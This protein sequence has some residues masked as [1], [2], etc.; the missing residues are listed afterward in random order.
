[1][2]FRD[3]GKPSLADLLGVFLAVA[4]VWIGGRRLFGDSDPAMHVAT[5]DWILAHGRI[6][7]TDPFSLTWAGKEWFAHEWLADVLWALVHRIAGWA[8]LVALAA[9]LVALTYVVLY[10]FLVRAG[11]H[12]LP[13]FVA[14]VAAAATA[15]SHWLA[16]PHLLTVL[17]LVVWTTTIEAVVDGRRAKRLLLFLPILMAL[18]VNLHGGFLIGFVVLGCYLVGD[19]FRARASVGPLLAAAAASAIATLANPYGY[20]LPL[21]LLTYFAR[22]RAQLASNAEFAPATLADRAGLALA[23]FLALCLLAV[24]CAWW[25][26]RRRGALSTAEDAATGVHS[27]ALLSFLATALMA[28]LSIRHA[29]LVGVFGAILI[30]RSLSRVIDVFVSEEDRREWRHLSHREARHGGAIFAGA[31]VVVVALAVADVPRGAGYDPS[32]FPVEAVEALERESVSPRGPVFSAAVWGGYLVLEWPRARVYVDGRTDMYGDEFM[33]RY[34]TIYLARPGW[35]RAL[36]AA[37]VRWAIL[38]VDAPLAR[39]MEEDGTWTL[40]RADDTAVVFRR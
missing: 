10:R 25:I 28:L 8:G 14:T 30:A 18:W 7:Y 15:A 9:M 33:D 17:L 37:G 32:R 34:A 19:L 35:G 6:P 5:G 36:E 39:A 20:R 21:H 3:R 29:E 2:G 16:R 22:P 40:W 13:A 4:V 11:A 12:A 24:A 31:L 38:P 23:G 26:R 27:G 1:M